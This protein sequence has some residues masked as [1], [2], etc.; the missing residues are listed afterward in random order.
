MALQD[1]DDLPELPE[2]VLTSLEQKNAEKK[3]RYL[4]YNCKET[5]AFLEDIRG[6]VKGHRGF[7]LQALL[8]Q[9]VIRAYLSSTPDKQALSYLTDIELK[10]DPSD[11]RPFEL[12][13][14]FDE[15]PFFSNSTLSKKYSLPKGVEPA[16]ADGSVTEQMASFSAD[17]LEVSVQKIDWKSDDKNL[18]KLQP[19]AQAEDDQIEGD[20]G[21]F[22][23]YFE[24]PTD[25]FGIGLTIQD[26][27]LP[28]AVEYYTGQANEDE[29]EFEDYDEDELD[30]ED[31]D[32]DEEIDLEDEE[33][34]PQKKRQRK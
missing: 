15:N 34:E 31:G 1:F 13:F 3:Y 8:N 30:E 9:D 20:F 29:G 4:R 27:V 25:D 23:W 5:L 16:P 17:E 12:V 24:S 28:D 14:H 22:F 26:E 32:D 7:W 11:P 33:D 21:S 6:L 18:C 10:Q 2:D 19:R